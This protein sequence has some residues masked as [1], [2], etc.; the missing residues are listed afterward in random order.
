MVDI[1]LNSV[2]LG[3]Q[4]SNATITWGRGD[5]TRHWRLF[6]F[7]NGVDGGAYKN[8]LASASFPLKS[9]QSRGR[10]LSRSVVVGLPWA[11]ARG[12]PCAK[13]KVTRLCPSNC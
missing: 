9:S 5:S 2:R 6:D 1:G 8:F 3:P 11:P 4:Y 12:C 7:P 10:G 13:P